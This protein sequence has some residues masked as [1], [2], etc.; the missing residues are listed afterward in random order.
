MKTA[1]EP[2][3]YFILGKMFCP[4]K[5]EAPFFANSEKSP[6]FFSAEKEPLFYG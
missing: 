6:M 2:M 1:E 5:N 3:G 4:E